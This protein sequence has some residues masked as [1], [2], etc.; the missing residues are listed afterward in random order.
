M[1][2]AMIVGTLAAAAFLGGCRDDRALGT[3]RDR[4]SPTPMT[5]SPRDR[6]TPPPS[7]VTV[8]P[9]TPLTDRERDCA[10]PIGDPVRPLDCPV[11][12]TP[13]RAP[14]PIEPSDDGRPGTEKSTDDTAPPSTHGDDRGDGKGDMGSPSGTEPSPQP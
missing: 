7:D 1:K 12:T 8:A 14:T 4:P 3:E 13:D 9:A 6:A 10:R 2:R 11:P 5:D